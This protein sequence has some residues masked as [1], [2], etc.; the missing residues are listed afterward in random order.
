VR[1]LRDGSRELPP[2]RH[3]EPARSEAMKC[4]ET[5]VLA[6]MASGHL[7]PERRAE[8]A[9]HAAGC[10]PCHAALDALLGPPAAGVPAGSM[11]STMGVDRANAETLAGPDEDRA[12]QRHQPSPWSPSTTSG[13]MRVSRSSR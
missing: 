12:R 11:E 6:A 10:A 5:E 4:P 9:N 13:L 3:A 8:I 7:S 1:I 2:D